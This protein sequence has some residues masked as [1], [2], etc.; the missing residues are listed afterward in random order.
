MSQPFAQRLNAGLFRLEKKL[1]EAATAA[2]SSPTASALK[3]QQLV[4]VLDSC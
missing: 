2:V 3:P 1:A 4:R